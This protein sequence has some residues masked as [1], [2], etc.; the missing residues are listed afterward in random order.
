M[1]GRDEFRRLVELTQAARSRVRALVAANAAPK[2]E[3][4]ALRRANYAARL[5]AFKQPQ[6]AEAVQGDTIDYQPVSFLAAGDRA[7]RAV[8]YVEVMA[9]SHSSTASGFL[10]SPRLFITN[11]HV[12]EDVTAARG[13]QIVF[14]RQAGLSGRPMATTTFFLDPDRCALFSQESVLDFAVVAVGERSAG[15]AALQDFGFCPL[16]SRGDKHAI[17]MNVNIVQHPNGSPKLIAIRNNVLTHRT[18]TTLLYET[19]TDHGTSGSPVFNDLWEVV[20]LHHYGEPFLEKTDENGAPIPQT[21]NEGVRISAIYKALDKLLPTL[22]G[23]AAELVA[24][25]LSYDKQPP[26]LAGARMLGPPRP[27]STATG[28][29]VA[30]A[31]RNSSQSSISGEK[32]VT[33]SAGQEFKMI[34]PIEISVRIG[35]SGTTESAVAA[36]Q[37]DTAA[38]AASTGGRTLARAAEKL[39]IDA[40]Y[41]N[42]RGYQPGFIDGFD[43]PMP[44]PDT[45]LAKQIATLRAD[46]PEP[47]KG[48]LRYEHFSLVLNRAKRVA[49]VTA[50]NIDGET[51]LTVDRGTGL[52]KNDA[53]EGET[54]FADPRVSASFFLGQD[55]YSAWSQFFDRG[56]LTRRSDP[57]WGT[58]E[59]AERAN[60]DTFH[61]T[62][63]SPQHFLFNQSSKYWQGVERYVLESGA[64]SGAKARLCVFQGPLYQDAIDRM[65]DD[66]QIPSSFFKVVFWHGQNGAQAVGLV[67]DQLPLLDR[68]RHGVRPAGEETPQ[69]NQWRVRISDIAKRAGLV[70]PQVVLDADTIAQAGQ[71]A[72]GEA[73]GRLIRSFDDI[74]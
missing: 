32:L 50:T 4:D 42:R 2:A 41:S 3:D 35:V 67:V 55:F 60:A 24:E 66:V 15:G 21:V 70:F 18:E 44:E 57:T 37:S 30:V 49:I 17:G 69:V 5:A 10:I 52:V 58:R 33:G 43:V 45:A 13:T 39:R 56:H 61:F 26:A 73:S 14:D 16:S 74:L 59:E 31:A 53:A 38:G 65:A 27:L 28:G 20:A 29:P 62:N 6:G 48:V 64:L 9:A 8:A 19:D 47:E 46:Q 51:Y 11:Q 34:V 68:T 72:V 36:P 54:W 12:I 22:S 40:D 63:C 7:Q 23:Q 1:A 71:P 25:A